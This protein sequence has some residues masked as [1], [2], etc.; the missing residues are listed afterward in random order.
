[1]IPFNDD[2]AA[3]IA[4]WLPAGKFGTQSI[5]LQVAMSVRAVHVPCATEQDWLSERTVGIGASEV[6]VII[7][8]SKF[9]SPYALWWQKKLGWRLPGTMQQRWG[10]LVED[11]IAT[12]FAEA[13]SDTLYVAKPVGHPYSLWSHPVH[14]WAMCTPDRLAQHIDGFVC[15]VELKSDEGG[16]GWGDPET[17]QV[18]PQCRAQAMWQS[19][20]FG[21]PGTYVVRK[22]GSGRSRL[23]WYWVPFIVAEA[24][25]LVDAARAFLMS[26]DTDEPP[27]PDGS[28]AT[29]NALKDLNPVDDDTF[30]DVPVE[31]RDEWIA[32]REAKRDAEAREKLASNMLRQA[33]GTAQ[34]ATSKTS[35]GLDVVFA[36]RRVGKRDGYTVAPGTVDELRRVSGQQHPSG[37]L[38]ARPGPADVPPASAAP[39][40]DE[41]PRRDP[42]TRV[43]ASDGSGAG[44]AEAAEDP[45]RTAVDD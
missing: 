15:P 33:M 26:L 25:A 30:A 9:T 40:E 28:E 37:D 38:P 27:L 23:V 42:R 3:R 35:D 12:L 17:D 13:M 18:P 7:G 43:G 31:V 19:F 8:A 41:H 20:I 29:A 24:Y 6:G 44:E 34:F 11:P 45:G 36:K 10:H 39:Q 2:D 1:M 4:A 16:D 21:S 32:A 22:R 5:Q 14:R